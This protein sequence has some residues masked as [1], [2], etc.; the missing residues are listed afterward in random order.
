MSLAKTRVLDAVNDQ[1]D[2]LRVEFVRVGPRWVHRILGV[3]RQ[4]ARLLL[5]SIEGDE[6]DSFPPSP[7]LQQIELQQLGDV[8]AAM[9]IGM[10]G[11]N[12][13]S[14]CVE[15]R[16]AARSIRWDV[17]CRGECEASCFFGNA[18]EPLV[19]WQACSAGLLL[20]ES[21]GFRYELSVQRGGT[22]AGS[23][24]VHEAEQQLRLQLAPD[25]TAATQRWCYE[26]HQTEPARP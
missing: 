3:E 9:L 14:V 15:A 11:R 26:F 8:T 1:G 18:Y 5:K 7:A 23:L 19:E 12:H 20:A 4:Q 13:W 17:A 2:G 24:V 21:N 6:T 22:D 16:P 25:P 10:A